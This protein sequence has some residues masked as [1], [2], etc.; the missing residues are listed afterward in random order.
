[1]LAAT[2]V[3][4]LGLLAGVTA[5]Q[6]RGLR[7]GGVVV[8]PLLAVYTLYSVRTFPVFVLSVAVA[9]LALSFVKRRTLV[10]GRPLFVIA[11]VTGALVP[12]TTIGLW[13]LL[14]DPAG[15]L[16]PI[17]FVGS[18]LPGIAAYNYHRLEPA[19]RFE[20]AAWSVGATLGLVWIGGLVATTVYVLE[21]SVGP[22]VLLTTG[23]DVGRLLGATTG[24]PGMVLDRATGTL[25]VSAGLVLAEAVRRRWGVRPGGVIALPLV[26]LF[27]LGDARIVAVFLCATLAAFAGVSGV[28]R[29]T[30]L[31]GRVL[32]SAAVLVGLLATLA[33]TAWWGIAVGTHAFLAGVLAGVAGYSLHV[34]APAERR[35]AVASGCLL[36]V[37]TLAVARAVATPPPGGLLR[38]V[39]PVDLLVL[40]VVV[41]ACLRE[42]YRLEVAIPGPLEPSATALRAGDAEP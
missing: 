32:M 35:A 12:V 39:G 22:P 10:H 7:L 11:L 18:I 41:A 19:R 27:A 42:C 36:F 33:V 15:S 8:V 25:L 9:Y 21:L 28:H 14:F 6:L 20:D 2:V 16:S 13:R 3:T 29:W 24:D 38:T 4:V 5:T 23:S 37:A 1:M 17:Q 26:A 40:G 34:V 30:L 31:Y